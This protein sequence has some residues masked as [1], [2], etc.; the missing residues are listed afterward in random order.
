M[1]QIN[2]CT[3]EAFWA[4]TSLIS[5]S[6]DQFVRKEGLHFWKC[7]LPWPHCC[8]WREALARMWAGRVSWEK[9]RQSSTTFPS[10]GN[11]VGTECPNGWVE[12]TWGMVQ[13]RWY[14]CFPPKPTKPEVLLTFKKKGS[15]NTLCLVGRGL[16]EVFPVRIKCINV[17]LITRDARNSCP[18]NKCPCF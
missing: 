17:Q 8:W 9:T 3:I 2:L 5:L 6:N 13:L 4:Q 18:N 12:P 14:L 10:P 7:F 1:R 15:S 11:R 16:G